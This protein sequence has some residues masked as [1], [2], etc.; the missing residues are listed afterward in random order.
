MARKAKAG[1]IA[2]R[3]SQRL[4]LRRDAV[5]AIEE[6]E[7]AI[8]RTRE[9]LK[10]MEAVMRR[11]RKLIETGHPA[12]EVAHQVDAAAARQA[13][14]EILREVQGAR[15]RAQRAQ[16]KLAAAEGSTLAEIARGWGVSRQ[17]VSRLVKESPRLR[18]R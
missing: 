10:Y 16:F 12:T 14:S 15:Q 5:R 11:V 6:F 9:Q 4:R 13:T 18:S 2:I 7:L 8:V 1:P 17:L 3:P